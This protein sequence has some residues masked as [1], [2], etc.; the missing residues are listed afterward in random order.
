MRQPPRLDGQSILAVFAHPDDES[1]SAGGTLARLADEG[2]RV[3]VVCATHGECG[4]GLVEGGPSLARRRALEL[5]AAVESLALHELILL[6]HPDG[7]LRWTD[8]TQFTAELAHVIARQTPAAII[9]F[10]Q[11]GLYWHPDHIGVHERVLSAVHT[12]GDAAPPVYG[13]TLRAEPI[14]EA[15]DAARARGW[16]APSGGF[17]NLP[18]DVFGR[19]ALP[20][21]LVIDVSDWV[22]RKVAAIC[23]HETQMGPIH[24]F[25]ELSPEDAR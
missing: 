19:H 9:T 3:T 17:W 22:P 2:A 10:D 5:R 1:L 12:F 24:P 16:Q 6:N 20:S 14:T 4:S 7:D 18:P 13:V 23:A 25:S 15:V 21:P 11:D 8:M